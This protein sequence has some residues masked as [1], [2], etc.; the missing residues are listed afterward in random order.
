MSPLEDV[1]GVLFPNAVIEGCSNDY[2]KIMLKFCSLPEVPSKKGR[3][4]S[5]DDSFIFFLLLGIPIMMFVE[6]ISVGVMM[7]LI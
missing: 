2:S 3:I 7:V 4:L 1:S 5:Y 6:E